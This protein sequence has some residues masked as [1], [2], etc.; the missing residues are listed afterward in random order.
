MKLW[1]VDGCGFAFGTVAVLPSLDMAPPLEMLRKRVGCSS[2]LRCCVAAV[3]LILTVDFCG[4]P[5]P[6]LI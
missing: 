4:D 3:A 5:D 1:L 2:A 6:M